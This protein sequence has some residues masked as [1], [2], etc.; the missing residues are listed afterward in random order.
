MF[1]LRRTA[2]SSTTRLP[3]GSG[4]RSSLSS[5][6]SM[7]TPD[8]KMVEQRQPSVLTVSVLPLSHS[9]KVLSMVTTAAANQWSYWWNGSSSGTPLGLSPEANATRETIVEQSLLDTILDNS[10]IYLISTL[11]R[12]RKMMNKHKLRKRRKKNRMNNKK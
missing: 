1:A 6:L 12:R 8:E 9:S 5:L 2:L 7:A 10:G 3:I 4:A 11:K